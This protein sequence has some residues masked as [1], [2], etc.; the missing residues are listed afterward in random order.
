MN[1]NKINN[2]D[3]CQKASSSRR[4]VLLMT[5][6]W[7][8]P[9]DIIMDFDIDSIN[10]DAFYLYEKA[11]RSR[12]S[13]HA[14]YI[15]CMEVWLLHRRPEDATDQVG[16]SR[17]GDEQA[18]GGKSAS[19]RIWSYNQQSVWYCSIFIIRF[20]RRY[21][22]GSGLSLGKSPS[23]Y[24]GGMAKKSKAIEWPAIM[25]SVSK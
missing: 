16:T 6:H 14:L 7:S 10:N 1:K 19:S 3:L 22:V 2:N 11:S 12:K 21:D 13:L 18:G 15:L 20:Q 8:R 17:K 5:R 25:R 24:K 4:I 9:S 23:G